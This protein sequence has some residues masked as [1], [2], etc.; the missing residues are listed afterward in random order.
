MGTGAGSGGRQWHRDS[1]VWHKGGGGGQA[2]IVHLICTLAKCQTDSS[3]ARKQL[4]ARR[5]WPA[6]VWS[7]PAWLVAY[8]Q[9]AVR[10][11]IRV[12]MV[13]QSVSSK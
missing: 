1:A 8:F 7:A 11:S 2:Y 9:G 12:P 4:S 6:L 13:G 3:L 10:A 5:V